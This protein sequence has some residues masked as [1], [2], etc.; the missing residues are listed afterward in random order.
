[1]A[2]REPD[3]VAEDPEL[4]LLPHLQRACERLPFE[5]VGTSTSRD[6]AAV[7][8]AWNGDGG[9]G[10]VRAAVFAL[11]G[12]VAESTTYVRQRRDGDELSFEVV[13]GA[14][15]TDSRFAPHGHALVFKVGN[16]PT[17]P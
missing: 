13:T 8:L 3:W 1:M 7:R 11:V 2:L 12:S 10:A 14:V 15:G 17:A 4:H 6:A 9:V 5:L 16:V